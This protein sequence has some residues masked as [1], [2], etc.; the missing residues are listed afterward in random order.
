MIESEDYE[1]STTQAEAHPLEELRGLVEAGVRSAQEG[2]VIA[3]LTDNSVT[4]LEP[5]IVFANR[6][7]YRLC[8]YREGELQGHSLR[9]LE[10]PRIPDTV[11][12]DI[13]QVAQET[14]LLREAYEQFK[15]CTVD[16]RY[17]RKGGTGFWC[18]LKLSPIDPE[19]LGGSHGLDGGKPD[20]YFIYHLRDVSERVEQTR[21]LKEQYQRLELAQEEMRQLAI[22]DGLTKIYNRRFFDQ[23]YQLYWNTAMRSQMQMGIFLL[24]IDAF[25]KYN[26]RYG[27]QEG[28]VVLAK[29][30]ATIQTRLRRSTDLLARYGG[31]EFVVLVQDIKRDEGAVLAE[32]ILESIRDLSIPHLDSKSGV[33]TASL[34]FVV[35]TPSADLQ[36]SRMLVEAD[37]ALYSAKRKGR[38]AAMKAEPLV[39]PLRST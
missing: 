28:D 27:H 37:Q 17:Y 38:D 36:P 9:S 33:V 4:D 6:G 3:Q 19:M 2:I 5:M 21:K 16:I 22:T 7:F 15:A 23:Q 30:A 29:V 12:F 13:E 20:R 10:A 26:D 24:D 8:G 39:F 11:A 14:R 18:E 25:K 1:A 34:G 31:E 35:F 32:G